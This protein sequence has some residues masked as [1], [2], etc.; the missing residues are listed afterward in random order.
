[1][2]PRSADGSVESNPLSADPC[3]TFSSAGRYSRW[4][5]DSRPSLNTASESKGVG[6]PAG[7]AR[8]RTP[9]AKSARPISSAV[10]SSGIGART[11][12][13]DANSTERL[14]RRGN[15]FLIRFAISEIRR[16]RGI[17]STAATSCSVQWASRRHPSP[18]AGRQP[19]TERS[20]PG[21]PDKNGSMSF[22]SSTSINLLRARTG[23]AALNVERR[24]LRIESDPP[25]RRVAL[26]ARSA[27]CQ[28][29]S[30]PGTV[31]GEA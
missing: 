25:E 13:G 30:P 16:S 9:N 31:A 20:S 18:S 15:R 27:Q 7:Y 14:K 12:D 8:R 17:F 6:R 4:S 11:E 29:P 26:A 5:P 19:T 3:H 23:R 28:R 2:C 10:D 22:R 24:S 21:A 1:M